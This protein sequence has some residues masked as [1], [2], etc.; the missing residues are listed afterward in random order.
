MS[1]ISYISLDD[2]E[3]SGRFGP[4]AEPEVPAR[5]LPTFL[6]SD[7]AGKPVPVRQWHV[8]TMIPSGT[9]TLLFGDG[10]TGK[11]LL[12]LQLAVA[13]A[14]R[15]SWLGLETMGGR[16]LYLSAEDDTDEL[17]RRLADIVAA[18]GDLDLSELHDLEIV[19]LAGEDAVL[20]APTKKGGMI[21]ATPLWTA[22]EAEAVAFEPTLIVADTLADVFGGD[23]NVRAQ[24]RQFIGMMKGIAILTGAAVVVLAHP[25][26]SGLASGSGTSGSTG[27]S[28]SVRSRLYFSRVRDGDN[29]ESDPDARVL[30]VK[31]ANY[32]RTG[33]EHRLR[34]EQGVFVPVD[35]PGLGGVNDVAKAARAERIFLELLDAY[36]T[37]KRPV[38]PSPSANYAPAV[39]ARDPRAADISKKALTNAMN[40]LFQTRQIE[41]CEV[42]P[43]SRRLKAIVRKA[44]R[45]DEE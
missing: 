29:Q 38:S 19:P 30:E 21:E 44:H 7:L 45:E 20:A 26:L 8:E 17:H 37:E 15:Q 18:S 16:A 23:E 4:P 41:I 9:V 28:N 3:R 13:T 6:A 24:A 43:P 5:K 40:Y 33:S 11:S 14:A 34:W 2:L 31:K 35:Q 25:S 27:W 1:N 42:G 32:A 36:N 12:S 39:F 10:G 22:L